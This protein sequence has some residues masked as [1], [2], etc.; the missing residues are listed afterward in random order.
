MAWSQADGDDVTDMR[1]D[2]IADFIQP[3]F[4]EVIGHN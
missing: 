2:W 1:K 4:R 3:C